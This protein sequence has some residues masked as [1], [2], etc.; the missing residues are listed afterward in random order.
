MIKVHKIRLY[1]NNK[2]ATY[3]KKACG[4]ARFAY[5]WGL[6]KWKTMF[7]AGEKPTGTKI[8]KE[9]NKI[10]KELFPWV[11]EVTKWATQ[12]VLQ[13]DLNNAFKQFFNKTGKYPQ[14]KKRGIRDSFRMYPVNNNLR[15]D[16][17]QIKIPRLG[18]VK[19]AQTLRFIGKIG[20]CTISR[21]ADKWFISI[22]VEVETPEIIHNGEN[23]TI[24]VDL[25]VKTFAT[26]SNGTVFEG[27]KVSKEFESKLRRI[28]K[29]LSRRVGSKKGEKKSKN[30]LKT[31]LKLSRLYLRMANVRNDQI[32]KLTY[33]LT[34]SFSIIGI[35]DLNVSGMVKNHKLAKNIQDRSFYEFRRQLEYKAL[36]TG[37]RVI[38][39][40]K[41]YASSKICNVCGNKNE[42]LELKDRVWIC[43]HCFTTHERDVNAAI[44]LK[45]N[46]VGVTVSACGELGVVDPSMKQEF[47]CGAVSHKSEEKKLCAE[48]SI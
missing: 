27:R 6:D 45:N 30:Y 42:N 37:S 20:Y 33:H 19:M 8:D 10:K 31:Q 7:E 47:S 46:A 28:Q 38:V 14:Y 34:Q 16:G 48:L 12:M 36:E 9:F 11:S 13:E 32:H 29:E 40:D 18:W 26:L 25:G 24:G 22:S 41:F 15:I 2:Q 5:N 39:A 21:K 43:S 35:E 1:P 17:L 23:Q 4:T 44:N 3:F